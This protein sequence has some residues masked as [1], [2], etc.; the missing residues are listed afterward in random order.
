[1]TSSISSS[2]CPAARASSNAESEGRPRFST[3]SRASPRAAARFGS[4]D[5]KVWA[6]S[7]SSLLSP[8]CSATAEWTESQY[9]QPWKSETPTAMDSCVRLS[10]APP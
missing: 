1:M 7:R 4:S 10:S 3:S 8:V 5:S 2:A 9:L 6:C